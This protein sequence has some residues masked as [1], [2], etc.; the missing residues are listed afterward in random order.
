MIVSPE[1]MRASSA[2]STRPLNICETRL[3]Q[4]TTAG[5]RGRY[6][7]R[8]SRVAAEIAAEG[9]G[10]LHQ[11][12]ARNDFD[13]VVEIFLVLHLGGLL[14]ADDDHR[15]HELVIGAPE[16]HFADRGLDFSA[17]L[18]GLYDI[19]WIEVA[20]VFDGLR[21]Q[22]QLHIGIVGAPFRLVA[23]LLVEGLDE[24]LGERIFVLKGP[25]EVRGGIDSGQQSAARFA[26]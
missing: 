9:V 2:P 20:G 21:P 16:V 23:V 11:P 15:S 14:A 25:P 3:A 6:L 19:G 8:A 24:H 17:R 7:W 12:L 26:G 4:F 22:R 18:V 10:L 13:D 1:L 5:S